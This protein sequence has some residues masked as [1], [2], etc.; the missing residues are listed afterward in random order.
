MGSPDYY[1]VKYKTTNEDIWTSSREL[2]ITEL[3]YVIH[4]IVPGKIYNVRMVAKN[5][6]GLQWGDVA[7][8]H[9]PT[10]KRKY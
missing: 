5:K 7:E 2:L 4:N 9:F 1:V 10:M 3:E 6:Y 8:I